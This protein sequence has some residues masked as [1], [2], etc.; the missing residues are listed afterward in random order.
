[1]SEERWWSNLEFW[2][3]VC[4]VAVL[5]GYHPTFAHDIN[6]VASS[7]P[8]GLCHLL[9]KFYTEGNCLNGINKCDS[10]SICW[11]QHSKVINGGASIRLQSGQ[12][13]NPKGN[14]EV[15]CCRVCVCI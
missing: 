2:R 1:M 8:R 4:E 11:R 5:Y 15:R 12:N 10:R 6:V 9:K 14:C 13:N 3:G 7:F